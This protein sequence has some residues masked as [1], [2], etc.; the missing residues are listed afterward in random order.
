MG[1]AIHLSLDTRTIGAVQGTVEHPVA[2]GDDTWT[3]PAAL[4]PDLFALAAAMQTAIRAATSDANWTVEAVTPGDGSTGLTVQ[5]AGATFDAT[6]PKIL[7][8]H[9]GWSASYAAQTAAT[10]SSPQ[11]FWPDL[12][13]DDWDV[14][15]ILRRVWDEGDASVDPADIVVDGIAIEPVWSGAL[16]YSEPDD[17]DVATVEAFLLEL[18]RGRAFRFYPDYPTTTTIWAEDN[19]TG[20]LDLVLSDYETSKA[21]LREPLARDGAVSLECRW[22]DY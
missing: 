12:P 9:V 17:T 6:F 3:L 21:W 7:Q 16:Q 1:V 20:Y 4:Y 18:L 14:G 19:R 22:V 13:I 11:G 15:Y 5:R 2:S 10:A 8:E